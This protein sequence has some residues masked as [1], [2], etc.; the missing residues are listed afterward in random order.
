MRI[1]FT[2]QTKNK[3]NNA[4]ETKLNATHG[5][6]LFLKSKHLFLLLNLLGWGNGILSFFFFLLLLFFFF[7]FSQEKIKST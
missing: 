7:P 3:S 2:H 5:N 6:F 4:K 1:Q